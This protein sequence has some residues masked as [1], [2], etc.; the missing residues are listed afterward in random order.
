MAAANLVE[1]SQGLAQNWRPLYTCEL[2]QCAMPG[3]DLYLG[4]SQ[5]RP[6]RGPNMGGRA[7]GRNRT[8]LGPQRGT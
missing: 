6:N 2:K 7:M 3:C 1:G 5:Q 8:S 4:V